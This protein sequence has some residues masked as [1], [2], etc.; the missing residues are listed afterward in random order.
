LQSSLDFM[1]KG[2][3]Q[4]THD[5]VRMYAMGALAMT[6]A[7][8]GGGGAQQQGTMTTPTRGTPAKGG[9]PGGRGSARRGLGGEMK[10]EAN[11]RNRGDGD[12]DEDDEDEEEEE[13]EESD[14]E[15]EEDVVNQAAAAVSRA[16]VER[17][18][19]L[20]QQLAD[21][22]IVNADLGHRLSDAEERLSN[23]TQRLDRANDNYRN[24]KQARS[25]EVGSINSEKAGLMSQ[26]SSL[27]REFKI[28]Q[29]R[30]S[31][32]SSSQEHSH[33]TLAK[34]R[35]DLTSMQRKNEE[36]ANDKMELENTLEDL[37]LDKEGLGQEKEALEDQLEE[38]KIDLESAQLELEDVKAQLEA[39]R[40]AEASAVEGD[41]EGG[42]SDDGAA[43]DVVRSLMLQNTR[44][45]TALIRLREQSELERNDLQRQLKIYQS[46]SVDKEE[47]RAELAELRKRHS[48]TLAE[49]HDLQD[50]IDQT[51][52]LEE[53]IETLSDK[54]WNLEDTN[55]KLERT[56]REMEE[57][58]E[59]AAE[60]EE[61]QAEELKMILRD[62]EGRD[63]LVRN[64]EEAIRM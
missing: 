61:V 26:L 21:M 2:A 42:A 37:V 38:M 25:D 55:A 45:R 12:E 41:D 54:V 16:L 19:E 4:S 34:L 31:D 43:Q 13:E 58:A 30:V 14:E 33:V 7:R 57:S 9:S 29:E 62:L 8:G 10:L 60:M 48:S 11:D 46:D 64:L 3:E 40:N 47:I 59:I 23:V 39:G 17:N 28:L 22:T 35:S 52:A 18:N 51:S 15:E 20:K 6:E 63:A 27:Q 5:A 32:K 56:I 1:S 53:T 24:E 49:M 36:L 50:T 44:L